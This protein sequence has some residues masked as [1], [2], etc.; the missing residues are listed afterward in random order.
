MS[1]PKKRRKQRRASEWRELVAQ[2]ESS[3]ESSAAFCEGHGIARTSLYA[4]KA[5]FRRDA[6]R[7]GAFVPVRVKREAPGP[8]SG[9][10]SPGWIEI[11]AVGG[12]ALRVHGEVDVGA[13]RR[14]LEAV[15]SC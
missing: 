15:E 8:R 10:D 11:S 3:D 5:R 14:V 4:W 9:V 13:L 2:W 1:K 7:S 12:R 6:A